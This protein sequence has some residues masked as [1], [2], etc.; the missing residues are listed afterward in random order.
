MLCECGDPSCQ[1]FIL[2]GLARYNELRNSGFLTAAAHTI[3]DG[4]PEL[5]EDGYWLQRLRRS[6]A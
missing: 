2:I 4:E 3:D 6:S 1:T 5:R